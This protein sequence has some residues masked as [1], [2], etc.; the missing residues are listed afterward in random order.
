MNLPHFLYPP[1][2]SPNLH[3]LFDQKARLA[4]HRKGLARFRKN[5]VKSGAID[6]RL[7]RE[8]CDREIAAN[9]YANQLDRMIKERSHRWSPTR[10]AQFNAERIKR[11]R[12]ATRK[13]SKPPTKA[14]KSFTK[15][16]AANAGRSLTPDE[17][18]AYVAAKGLDQ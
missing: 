16:K 2:I 10:W 9:D 4:S 7:W 11:G 3:V 13:R 5:S 15:A 17:I 8:L 14:R 1:T 12:A 18:T 6:P